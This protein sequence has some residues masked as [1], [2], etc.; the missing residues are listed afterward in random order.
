[1]NI[2]K[3]DECK[4]EIVKDNVKHICNACQTTR[5]PKAWKASKHGCDCSESR[6]SQNE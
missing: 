2:V 5:D 4:Q 3:C 6:E 1:M